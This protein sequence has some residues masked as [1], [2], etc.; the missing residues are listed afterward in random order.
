MKNT[1]QH[2]VV[3]YGTLR[4]G[5][6]NHYLLENEGAAYIGDGTVKGYGMIPLGG[7]PGAV[8]LEQGEIKTEMYSVDDSVLARLDMLEG[9]PNFYRRTPVDFIDK[10]GNVQKA[11]IYV[12]QRAAGSRP[13]IKSGDWVEFNSLSYNDR[14]AALTS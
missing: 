8:P 13:F 9:H 14:N 4:K 2:L 6:S 5:Q 10:K 11:E 7:F 1:K 12:L 3:V